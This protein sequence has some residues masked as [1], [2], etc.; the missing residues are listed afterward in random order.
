MH[1]QTIVF[2]AYATNSATYYE[3][4][5]ILLGQHHKFEHACIDQI[6][7]AHPTCEN[8]FNDMCNNRLQRHRP[9]GVCGCSRCSQ[10]PSPPNASLA[11]FLVARGQ[12]LRATRGPS[13]CFN[14]CLLSLLLLKG[15]GASNTGSQCRLYQLVE[16]WCC[17]C[18]GGV[19]TTRGPSVGCIYVGTS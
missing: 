7:H 10:T 19:P 8:V 12:G 15:G 4:H 3:K 13:V 6:M 2:A 17:C 18:R 1:S 14:R 9:C 16:S 5:S 11:C